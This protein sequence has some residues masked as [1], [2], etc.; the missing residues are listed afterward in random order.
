MPDCKRE[1]IEKLAI[2]DRDAFVARFRLKRPAILVGGLVNWPDTLFDPAQ[3][4][5]RFGRERVWTYKFPGRVPAVRMSSVKRDFYAWTDA[6]GAREHLLRWTLGE[7]IAVLQDGEPHYCMVNNAKNT[8]LRDLLAAEAGDFDCEPIGGTKADF[9]RRE[10]FF[11]SEYAG[12][13]L[14][15]DGSVESFLFQ[16]IGTKRV[17]VFSPEDISCLYPTASWF[18]PAGHFSAVADS[19]EVDAGKFPLFC[20][21]TAYDCRLEPGDV[22]YLP[23]Y[24]YHDTCPLGPTLSMTVRN[25]PPTDQWGTPEARD[26]IAKAAKTLSESFGRLSPEARTIYR[27]L[28]GH[29]LS[30]KK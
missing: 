27:A 11:G 23:P 13:G 15:H 24:W 29:E 16:L 4:A 2:S 25:E 28:L 1:Y 14:H 30:E 19:F 22:L 20:Q 3:I 5:A 17:C 21:A 9:S 26:E 12:P 10:F 7:F 18:V 6:E 8:R